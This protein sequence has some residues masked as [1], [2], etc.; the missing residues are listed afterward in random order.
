MGRPAAPLGCGFSNQNRKALAFLELASI[1][2]A[3]ENDAIPRD[4]SNGPVST[5]QVEE[6]DL[7][8]LYAGR[9]RDDIRDDIPLTNFSDQYDRNNALD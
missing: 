1:D 3:I 2:L 5:G 9:L 6:S 7:V 8:P 4:V